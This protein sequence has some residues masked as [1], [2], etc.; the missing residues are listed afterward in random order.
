MRSL[1][2]YLG[3][4]EDRTQEPRLGYMPQ[5]VWIPRKSL[6]ITPVFPILCCRSPSLGGEHLWENSVAFIL[7]SRQ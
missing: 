3:A 2:Q 4:L 5:N 7:T 6:L 1:C